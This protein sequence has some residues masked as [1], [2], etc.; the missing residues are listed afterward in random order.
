MLHNSSASVR[1]FEYLVPDEVISYLFVG[2]IAFYP[3]FHLGAQSLDDLFFILIVSI[4]HSSRRQTC[5]RIVRLEDIL[6]KKAYMRVGHHD[7]L[8]L[9]VVFADM[10]CLLW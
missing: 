4:D 3:S 7:L 10:D 9:I 8:S 1:L 5:P 2:I 6:A